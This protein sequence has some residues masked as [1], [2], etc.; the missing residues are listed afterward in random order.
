M[1]NKLSTDELNN[2]SGGCGDGE[3]KDFEIVIYYREP[4][5]KQQYKYYMTV[6]LYSHSKKAPD[7]RRSGQIASQWC[8]DNGK[9]YASWCFKDQENSTTP[10]NR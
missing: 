10:L 6:Q 3:L 7:G 4:G 1:A 9:E 8:R 5:F 2:V